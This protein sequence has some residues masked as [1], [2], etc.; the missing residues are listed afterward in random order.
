MRSPLTAHSHL[1]AHNTCSGWI[2]ENKCGGGTP[3]HAC[4][5]NEM[6]GLHCEKKVTNR[7]RETPTN[8]KSSICAH[9]ADFY[10]AAAF[11]L[12]FL[13]GF[14]TAATTGSSS[15]ATAFFHKLVK[16]FPIL[17]AAP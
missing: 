8:N 16:E 2:N 4:L 11:L 17:D 1:P 7:K 13:T 6:G 5:P 3:Q 14:A 15:S 12:P 9:H 10:T